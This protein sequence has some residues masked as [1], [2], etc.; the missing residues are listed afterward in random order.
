[1]KELLLECA[2][3]HPKVLGYP[4]PDVFL[5][6]FNGGQLDFELRCFLAEV[7]DGI[8]VRSDLRFAILAKLRE[9]DIERPTALPALPD[10]SYTPPC[11]GLTDRCSFPAASSQRSSRR[12]CLLA[13]VA[14]T[15]FDLGKIFKGGKQLE[16]HAVAID[17]GE[18]VRILS[19]YRRKHGL[20]PLKLD[21]KLTQDRRR[22]RD[23][24]GDA[25]TRSIMCCAAKAA[26]A[27]ACSPGGYDAAVASENIGGGY[28]SLDEAFAGWRKSKEH[29][30]NMLRPD[31][32]VMGI[33]RADSKGSKYGTYW[34]LV[35]AR[36]YEGPPPGMAGPDGRP[37]HPRHAVAS[38]SGSAGSGPWP[39]RGPRISPR[40][41]ATPARKSAPPPAGPMTTVP[42]ARR[43]F[44]T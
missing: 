10:K 4:E 12:R 20:S 3:S 11:R 27:S 35:L 15:A 31:V 29:N 40:I 2:R 38:I 1:M 21:D 37:D 33:A 23:A 6:N 22:P 39:P 19:D 41:A 13:P 26:S 16:A 30:K 32:T 44:Q 28:N 42:M 9:A 25:W 5:M 8:R 36:P 17:T 18:A 7:S 43:S 24:H 14:A 34:S